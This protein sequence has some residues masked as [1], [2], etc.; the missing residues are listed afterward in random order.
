MARRAGALWA[1][2]IIGLLVALPPPA[3]AEAPAYRHYVACGLSRN[4][5]PTHVCPRASKKGA[6]FKTTRHAVTYSVC[7]RFPGGRHLCA[8]RQQAQ[9]GRL[10]VN[11][12]SSRIPR[13]ALGHLV[14][15]G[16]AGGDVRLL[17]P[18]LDEPAA[19]SKASFKSSKP[20]GRA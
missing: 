5:A 8:K 12:I 15:R 9:Q 3:G 1:A 14:R 2:L 17:G 18:A 20:K 10:Y 11:K 13:Q 19:T 16:Q 4:A 7:A 6:F